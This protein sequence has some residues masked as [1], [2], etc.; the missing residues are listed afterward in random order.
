M[1]AEESLQ[2]IIGQRLEWEAPNEERA[3]WRKRVGLS[4]AR[5]RG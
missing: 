1:N 2:D 3:C 4:V 5:R